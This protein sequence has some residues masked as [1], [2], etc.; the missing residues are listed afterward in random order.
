M[1]GVL[2]AEPVA[3]RVERGP[4]HQ[5]GGTPVFGVEPI[6]Q[7]LEPEVGLLDAGVEHR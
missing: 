7:Q 3:Q 1:G 5:V 2:G 4:Q 6:H